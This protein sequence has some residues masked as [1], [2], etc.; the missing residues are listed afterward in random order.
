MASR[1]F[2]Q[3]GSRQMRFY[4]D[5]QLSHLLHKFGMLQ[6]GV[7]WT[8]IELLCQSNGHPSHDEPHQN[9]WTGCLL[10]QLRCRLA[11]GVLRQH[12]THA[13]RSS[14]LHHHVGML[15]GSVWRTDKWSLH[16]EASI[17]THHDPHQIGCSR[18]RLLP[19]LR[20]PLAGRKVH[21]HPNHSQWPS[22]LHYSVGLL[23]GR[24]W[25]ADKWSLHQGT[26]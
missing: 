3:V 12:R 5:V 25:W 24:I 15:Q 17:T 16:C 11:G 14:C 20:S 26:C 19:Q 2:R 4:H 10:S 18:N 7:W 22:R 8:D 21:Q 1:L 9:W 23:Q 6:G 13:K